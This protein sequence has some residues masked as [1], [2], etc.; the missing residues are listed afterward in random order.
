MKFWRFHLMP[1]KVN[2]PSIVKPPTLE[3]KHLPSHLKYVF[4]ETSQQLPVIVSADLTEDQ[5]ARLLS[6]LRSV[7]D[8]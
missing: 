8:L 7:G 6:L 1:T 2:I 5:E 3:L 4:L